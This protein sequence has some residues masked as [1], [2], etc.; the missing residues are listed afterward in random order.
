MSAAFKFAESICWG[1]TGA[2]EDI[3][4][5]AAEL[6]VESCAINH[7]MSAF[8]IQERAEY[9]SGKVIDFP[10]SVMPR[11]QLASLLERAR[12]QALSNGTFTEVGTKWL[13]GPL[14][15][16]CKQLNQED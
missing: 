15:D 11:A 2:I 5:R 14:A 8:L 6:L 1:T 4:S 16:F 7:P 10:S 9:W 13:T 12:E 3:L